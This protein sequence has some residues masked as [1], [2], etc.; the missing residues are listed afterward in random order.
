MTKPKLQILPPHLAAPA[1]HPEQPIRPLQKTRL[2][3]GNGTEFIGIES[4]TT[5]K[6]PDSALANIFTIQIRTLPFDVVVLDAPP[7]GLADRLRALAAKWVQNHGGYSSDPVDSAV[8]VAQ[9]EC[10]DEL[11]ELLDE[12]EKP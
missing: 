7:V 9:E 11:L 3:D 4:V 2:Y 5:T 8:E 10:A 1:M 12:L 6:A